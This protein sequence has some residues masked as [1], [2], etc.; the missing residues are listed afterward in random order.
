V[1]NYYK[2]T[3]PDTRVTFLDVTYFDNVDKSPLAR[4]SF[5]F[6]VNGHI[7]SRYPSATEAPVSITRSGVPITFTGG[8]TME[9]KR[10]D[11]IEIEVGISLRVFGIRRSPMSNEEAEATDYRRYKSVE[12]T[13]SNS[14]ANT[15]NNFE[16]IHSASSHKPFL[17]IDYAGRTTHE[18]SLTISYRIDKID[19]P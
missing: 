12:I 18:I 3:V 6:S 8:Q 2:G 1:A 9:I 16:G 11:R 10:G 13:I 5:S 14:H 15:D 19:S 17:I 4:A 7:L